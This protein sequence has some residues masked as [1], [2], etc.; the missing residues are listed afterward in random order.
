MAGKAFAGMDVNVGSIKVALPPELVDAYQFYLNQK[1]DTKFTR[2]FLSH[3]EK[4]I[5]GTERFSQYDYEIGTMIVDNK[6]VKPWSVF[7]FSDSANGMCYGYST[8][9]FSKNSCYVANNGSI[10]GAKAYFESLFLKRVESNGMLFDGVHP[11]VYYDLSRT[12]TLDEMPMSSTLVEYFLLRK[13]KDKYGDKD[14]EANMMQSFKAF[15]KSFFVT[16]YVEKNARYLDDTDLFNVWSNLTLGDVCVNQEHGWSVRIDYHYANGVFSRE[17]DCAEVVKF[18]RGFGYEIVS[19]LEA[20]RLKKAYDE[21]IVE[22]NEREKNGIDEIIRRNLLLMPDDLKTEIVKKFVMKK[23][24]L[25]SFNG[26]EYHVKYQEGSFYNHKRTGGVDLLKK[27]YA[28]NGKA[29]RL[30]KRFDALGEYDRI[31]FPDGMERRI[32]ELLGVAR[33][34]WIVGLQYGE[35]N[36]ISFFYDWKLGKYVI[37]AVVRG[38]K[39][40]LKLTFL[41]LVNRSQERN[42]HFFYRDKNGMVFEI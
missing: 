18:L 9:M 4:A 8:I 32:L 19:D 23:N 29:P 30:L 25:I 10:D 41:E 21:R 26:N 40:R 17:K 31:M 6:C 33:T 2:R 13:S 42:V 35:K 11:R 12:C 34:S 7:L 24:L 14:R 38:N 22:F 16:D 39:S 28:K 20:N 3:V 15:V 27:I 1:A 36:Q 5:A 37:E